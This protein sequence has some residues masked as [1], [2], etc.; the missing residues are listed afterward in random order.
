[1]FEKGIGSLIRVT[2]ARKKMLLGMD[3]SKPDGFLA[4]VLEEDDKVIRVMS[5]G[6]EL[7]LVRAPEYDRKYGPTWCIR[8]EWIPYNIE[9]LEIGG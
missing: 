3:V 9:V 8:D 4:V 2:K 1:M 6:R 7:K 5:N